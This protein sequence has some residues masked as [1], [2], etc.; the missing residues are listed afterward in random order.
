MI[1]M[2]SLIRKSKIGSVRIGRNGTLNVPEN[3]TLEPQADGKVYVPEGTV[4]TNNNGQS[5]TAPEGGAVYD[6]ATGKLLIAYTVRF[7]S[8]GGSDIADISV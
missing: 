2:P 7:N 6:P 1:S 3:G 5:S 4:V 8:N